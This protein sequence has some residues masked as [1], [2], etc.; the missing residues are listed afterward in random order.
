MSSLPSRH[1][2]EDTGPGIPEQALTRIFNRFYSGRPEARFG[3]NSG[4]GLPIWHDPVRRPLRLAIPGSQIKGEHMLFHTSCVAIDGRAV[5]IL[6]SAGSGKS[7]LALQLMAYGAALVADDR[8]HV[9]VQDG[10]PVASAPPALSGRIEARGIGILSAAPAPATRIVLVVDLDR[11]ETGRLP[12]DRTYS[13]C[14]LDMPLLHK[15]EC[16]HFTPAILHY[17]KGG[18]V[19]M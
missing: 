15:S 12:P 19:F 2:V 9:T 17:L 18:K 7:S 11:V 10:W 13:L 3:N 14:G 5:L 16:L 6:G 4:L 8:T 1:S